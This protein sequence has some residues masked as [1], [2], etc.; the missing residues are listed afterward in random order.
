MILLL[1]HNRE[2]NCYR[3][4]MAETLHPVKTFWKRGQQSCVLYVGRG[5]FELRLIEDGVVV[6][7]EACRDSGDAYA[8]SQRWAHEDLQGA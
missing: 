4:R 1:S 7:S 8:K 6:R 3:R 2:K 5:R